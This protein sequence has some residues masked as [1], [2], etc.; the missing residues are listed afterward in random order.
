[1]AAWGYE[2]YL[3]LKV[4]LTHSLCSLVRDTFSTQHWICGPCNIL[5]VKCVSSSEW[6]AMLQWKQQQNA[7][8]WRENLFLGTT[9]IKVFALFLV[10]NHT[11]QLLFVTVKCKH[12]HWNRKLQVAMSLRMQ[13]MRII[14]VIMTYDHWICGHSS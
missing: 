1:M 6:M 4:S 10:H 3:V 12:N 9:A 2:F 8:N 7:G 11:W 14:K 13:F 5:Y